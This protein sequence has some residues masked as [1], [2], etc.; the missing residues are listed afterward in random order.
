MN[1]AKLAILASG[2]VTSVGLDAASSCAAIRA[3]LSNPTQTRFM[4]SEG[5]WIMGHGVALDRPWRG[6]AKLVRMAALAIQDCLRDIPA[7]DWPGIPMLLCTAERERL[8]RLDGLDEELFSELQRQLN[9]QFSEDSLVVP[10]GRVA[11]GVALSTAQRLLSEGRA[12]YVLIAAT[13]SLLNGETLS[14]CDRN[15]RLL[16]PANSNGFVPGEGAAAILLGADDAGPRL[17]CVGLGSGVEEATIDSDAPMRADGLTQAIRSALS[18]AGCEM[19]AIDFRITDLSGE[20]FYFKEASLAL[21][22][23]LHTR[24]ESADIWHPAECIGECGSVG[25]LAALVVAEAACR[26]GYA[27]GPSILCHASADSGRRV[28][29]VLHFRA[30]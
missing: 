22:R 11:A 18:D 1:P 30:G 20:Q 15:L 13:D 27:V 26:K 29:S 4:D 7:E 2:L 12:P 24:K 3:K 8:G 6:R 23:T 17:L 19:Q 28:A 16:T 5:E 10:Q 21:S 9:V 14:E 25:G